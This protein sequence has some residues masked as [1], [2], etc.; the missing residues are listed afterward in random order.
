MN[1][2]PRQQ[3]EQ[4]LP[5]LIETLGAIHRVDVRDQLNYGTFNDDGVGLFLRFFAKM[6]NQN[7]YLWLRDRVLALSSSA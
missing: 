2:L 6:Q 3:Y 7:G 5:A 1:T 4:L